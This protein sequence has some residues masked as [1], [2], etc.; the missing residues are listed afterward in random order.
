MEDILNVIEIAYL[1]VFLVVLISLVNLLDEPREKTSAIETIKSV[2]PKK[3]RRM[4]AEEKDRQ[5]DFERSM[6]LMKNVDVYDG[7]SN[8]QEEIR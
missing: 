1:L 2:L 8:G 3:R 4:S 5:R 6:Q 7:T